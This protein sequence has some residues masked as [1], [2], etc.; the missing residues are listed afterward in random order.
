MQIQVEGW[1]LYAL[2][3]CGLGGGLSEVDMATRSA[4]VFKNLCG[5]RLSVG[6]DDLLALA[7]NAQ[8]VPVGVPSRLVVINRSNRREV[9]AVPTGL[10]VLDLSFLPGGP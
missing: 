10:E 3:S 5:E 6:P 8:P 1:L 7:A 2:G 4:R 9:R